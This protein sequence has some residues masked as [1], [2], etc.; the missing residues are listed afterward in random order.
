VALALAGGLTVAAS[1]QHRTMDY[2]LGETTPYAVDSGPR[3][4]G[5]NTDAVLFDEVVMVEGSAWMRVFFGKMELG[6]RS[7]VRVTSLQDGEVQELDADGLAMWHNATAY[8]NGDK[9]RVEL[10]GGP[11]TE[12][13]RLVINE[14]GTFLH[15]PVG[16]AGQ[17]GMCGGDDRTPSNEDWTGRLFPAGCT[18]SVYNPDSCMVTA[19]HCVSGGMVV[20]FRVPNSLGSCQPVNPPVAD[21]FSA[22]IFSFNNNGVGDDWGVLNTGTN[23]LGQTIYERYGELRSIATNPAS[24]GAPVAVTGYGVDQTCVLSQTQQFSSGTICQ[25]NSTFYEHAVDA[26]FG[27]SGSAL[28]HA[29][30]IIG[31]NTHCP[32]CNIATRIDNADF[33][34]AIENFCPGGEFNTTTLPFFDDFPGIELDPTLW[35]GVDGAEGST[36]GINEPSPEHSLNCDA[37]TPGGDEARTAIMNTSGVP[38]AKV[39]YWYQ[40]AGADDSP[41]DGDDLVVEYLNASEIW[42]E[43]NRHLGSGPDMTEYDFVSITLPAGAQHSGFRLRFRSITTESSGVDDHFVDDVC[44]GSPDDCPDVADPCPWDLDGSG[45]V[46][47]ADLLDLLSQWGTNPGGP[48]DFDGGGVGTSDLLE[49]LSN[50]GECP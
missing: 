34:G 50:W 29:D 23:N 14:V 33:A 11:N 37:T 49:L 18:A 5:N 24:G 21:Q 10:I 30:Q 1:A 17:C 16:G 27:N 15:M 40:R 41:E 3:D 36:R 46:G 26:T 48:P 28:I 31:I 2:P 9:V 47:T 6:P 25:V 7:F 39:T 20:Q 12:S 32:C 22:S 35:S 44:I 45:S 19:G 4:N 13:N 38:G 8:F 42:V 43:L